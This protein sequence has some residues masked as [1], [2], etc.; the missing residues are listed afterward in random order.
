MTRKKIKCKKKFLFETVQDREKAKKSCITKITAHSQQLFQQKGK[1]LK[2]A[3]SAESANERRENAS[4]QLFL[5]YLGMQAQG[6]YAYA[7]SSVSS[8]LAF[9]LQ[10]VIIEQPSPSQQQLCFFLTK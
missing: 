4:A 5:P 1:K 10:S 7:R 6:S 2:T 3:L 8:T 9:Q